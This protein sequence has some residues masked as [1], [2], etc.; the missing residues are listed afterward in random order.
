M[1]SF[2]PFIRKL[3]DTIARP[4]KEYIINLERLDGGLNL[5]ELDY[6]LESN[7]SPN[8]INMYWVDGAL[9]SRQGQEYIN[10]EALGM[11]VAAYDREYK[12]YGVFHAG[13]NLYK[14]NI[15]SGEI[16]VIKEN[17][18]STAGGTF[19]TFKNDLYYKTVGA[20]LKIS[21]TFT[22]TVVEGYIPTIAMNSKPNGSGA[23]LYQSENRLSR[24]KKVLYTSDGSS[25]TYKLP[26]DNCDADF[27]PIVKVSGVEVTSGYTYNAVKGEVVFTEAI[28][29]TEPATQNNVEITYAKTNSD[30]Y[31][32]VMSCPYAATYG[33]T[34]DVCVVV[35]GSSTQANI[36]CWSGVNIVADASYFPI[37]YYNLAD[38]ADERIT[39]FG[40]QQDM[41]IVFKERS[42]GK[43]SFSTDTIND[44]AVI[45]LNYTNINSNIGC[46]LPRTIQLVLNNLVFAN[47]YAGVYALL[48]TSEANENNILRISRNIN[49]GVGALDTKGLL[50][51]IKQSPPIRV[52]SVDDDT[53]YWIVANGNAYVWDY[54]L[55][56]NIADEGRLSW[57]KFDNIN[58]NAWIK[59]SNGVYYGSVGGY[60]T[61]FTNKY[62]D[63]GESFSR[64]Y[65]FAVQSF[66]GHSR[67]KDVFKV[68]FVTRTDQETYLDITYKTDYGTRMDATP[69]ISMGYR[70]VPRNLAYRML[71]VV[72]YAKVS[73]RKPRALH[74]RHFAMSLTNN[75]KGTG[76]SLVSAQ[77]FYKYSGED[78]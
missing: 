49:G 26:V 51:D 14:M 46:D 21:A 15:A 60:W 76:M 37:E 59:N 34:N 55:S 53:R 33:S 35:G 32:T 20:Y 12:G 75:K 65:D 29:Q 7:Q 27:T 54:T 31:N 47:S 48:D 67:L 73:V 72:K 43:V 9:S 1:G 38:Q 56:S 63:Y 16:V 17:I 57:F 74:I 4:P 10:T 13:T 28:T 61:R 11:I 42:V 78:R 50:Y 3:S 6:R 70:L 39:G 62:E 64:V 8:L 5:W 25:K 30:A 41:L 2:N 19:F 58:A 22:V 23:S 71:E 77:I 66:G 45:T 18:G 36:Y 24:Y 40:K 44:K 68:I 52:T 69:I